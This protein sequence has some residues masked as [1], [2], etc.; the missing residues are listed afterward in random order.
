M[1]QTSV[2]WYVRAEVAG[3]LVPL[4]DSGLKTFLRTN[5]YWRG[6]SSYGT[7]PPS[8][9]F[10]L[11]VMPSA[12]PEMCTIADVHGDRL[13][14]IPDERQVEASTFVDG[15]LDEYRKMISA[16]AAEVTPRS[17]GFIQYTFKIPEDKLLL[18]IRG[19]GRISRLHSSR[20]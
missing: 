4:I 9:G 14:V 6:R 11:W 19:N 3:L 7:D 2:S 16:V 13:L 12:A 17:D 20:G 5:R 10:F 1:V 8:V 18:V 15:L